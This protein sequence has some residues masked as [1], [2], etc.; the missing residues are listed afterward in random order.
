MWKH[1]HACLCLLGGSGGMSPTP[2]KIFNLDLF[3]LQSGTN[4]PNNILMT[5]TALQ[6]SCNKQA[7]QWKTTIDLLQ[8]GRYAEAGKIIRF[9]CGK[10][11]VVFHCSAW[12]LQDFVWPVKVDGTTII[13]KGTEV[14]NPWHSSA[15]DCTCV[16]TGIDHCLV[17]FSCLPCT[18]CFVPAYAKF[19]YKFLTLFHRPCATYL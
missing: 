1:A 15:C 18:F 19:A 8:R 12:V 11:I 6:K 3:R 7:E 9:I 17:T 10:S 13:I 2:R 16:L 14:P 4:F 5:H